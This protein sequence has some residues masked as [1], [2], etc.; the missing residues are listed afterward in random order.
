VANRTPTGTLSPETYVGYEH[1]QDEAFA[2]DPA[3]VIDVPTRY[4]LP[5]QLPLG[6]LGFGG[7]WTVSSEE[8]TAG[9]AAQ[10]ELGFEAADVYLVLGGDGTVKV[11]VDGRSPSTVAVSGVPGLYTLVGAPSE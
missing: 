6:T 2:A 5:S 9:P 3:L 1:L 10:F 8:A 11:S 7:T 4:Q